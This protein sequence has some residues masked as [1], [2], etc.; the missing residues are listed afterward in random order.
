MFLKD[1]VVYTV[2]EGLG[3]YFS[4]FTVLNVCLHDVQDILKSIFVS[5][6]TFYDTVLWYSCFS[7]F[8]PQLYSVLMNT[9]H[10]NVNCIV[11]V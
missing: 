7:H 6:F 8:L 3:R 9:K 11:L 4:L 2:T 1:D 10:H 5:V